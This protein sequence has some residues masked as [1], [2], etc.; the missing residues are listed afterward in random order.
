MDETTDSG[1]ESRS[2]RRTVL[3][4]IASAGAVVAAAGTAGAQEGE[5][6]PTGT[7]SPTPAETPDGGDGDPETYLASISP[8]ARVVDYRIAE[9]DTETDDKARL[10]VAVESDEPQL[11][12]LSDVF[13]G[14]ASEG[15]TNVPQRRQVLPAGRGELSLDASVFDDSLAAVGV[16]T[17]GGAVTVSTGLPRDAEDTVSLGHGIASGVTTGVTGVG[18][19]AW[20]RRRSLKTAVSNALKDSGWFR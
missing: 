2:D 3:K 12:V 16:A 19:A 11:F 6:T 4:G 8:T 20:Y 14:V 7:P 5:S 15:V 17:T 10:T 9:L 13:A 18:L 1:L